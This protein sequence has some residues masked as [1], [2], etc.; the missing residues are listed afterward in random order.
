[1]NHDVNGKFTPGNTAS[2]GH[3]RPA[4]QSQQTRTRD[5][6]PKAL[7]LVLEGVEQGDVQAASALLLFK[8]TS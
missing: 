7:D 5:L 8:S 4:G 3:G 6:M 1:M 2:V